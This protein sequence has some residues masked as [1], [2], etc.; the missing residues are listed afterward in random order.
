MKEQ[1]T[2]Y[3]KTATQIILKCAPQALRLFQKGETK[4]A[5]IPYDIILLPNLS[6]KS[7]KKG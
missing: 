7:D 4:I 1:T 2:Q 3:T 6:S 5:V